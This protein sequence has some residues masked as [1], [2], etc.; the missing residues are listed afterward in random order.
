M[1]ETTPLLNVSERSVQSICLLPGMKIRAH[2]IQSDGALTTISPKEAISGARKA[3]GSYWIDVDADE[4]DQEELCEWL[5]Q[6]SL[7]PFLQNRLSRP[8]HTWDSTVLTLDGDMELIIVRIL[9]SEQTSDDLFHMAA[10]LMPRLLLTFTSCPRCDTGGLYEQAFAS[11]QVRL[12]DASC[13]GLL[14]AW[15][16]FHVERTSLA[17]RQMR[18]LTLDMDERMDHQTVQSVPKEQVIVAKDQLLRILAVAEEQL[19]CIEAIEGAERGSG[20][21]LDFRNLRGS[22]GVLKA[23]ASATERMAMRLNTHLADLRQRHESFQHE[24]M[25]RRLALLTMLSAVFLPLTLL[26]GLW[27]VS[28]DLLFAVG[29]LHDRFSWRL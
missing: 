24:H 11:L 22:F 3:R 9:P 16:Q 8:A 29:L 26:T 23:T 13:S 1:T 12:A 2:G 15:M 14:V 18:T 19:E 5:E 6:L 20:K 4:R 17:A 10:L 21:A 7:S 27:G 28:W 25:N